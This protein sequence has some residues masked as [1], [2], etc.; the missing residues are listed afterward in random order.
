MLLLLSVCGFHPALCPPNSV[1]HSRARPTQLSLGQCKC[2]NPNAAPMQCRYMLM[3][4]RTNENVISNSKI[5]GRYAKCKD[6]RQRQKMLEQVQ[7]KERK[8]KGHLTPNASQCK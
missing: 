8:K 3:D 1:T 6:C 4:E 5:C 2:S 7:K